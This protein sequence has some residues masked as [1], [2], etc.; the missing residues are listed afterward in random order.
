MWVSV[1]Y[2]SYFFGSSCLLLVMMAD[3]GHR[4]MGVELCL[5]FVD[6]VSGKFKVGCRHCFVV[7]MDATSL[8]CYCDNNWHPRA[9]VDCSSV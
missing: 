3:I 5:E 1:C 2:G 7:G 4:A 9:S 6:F 8:A